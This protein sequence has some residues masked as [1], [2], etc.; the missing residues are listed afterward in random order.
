MP[1]ITPQ[2]PITGIYPY[3]NAEKQLLQLM[4]GGNPSFVNPLIPAI[5]NIL[6]AVDGLKEQLDKI[7]VVEPDVVEDEFVDPVIPEMLDMTEIPLNEETGSV[8][9]PQKDQIIQSLDTLE[10][11]SIPFLKNHSDRLSGANLKMSASITEIFGTSNNPMF[12]L[13]ISIASSYTSTMYRIYGSSESSNQVDH[14]S[15]IFGTI[16]NQPVDN[17]GIN[18]NMDSLLREISVFIQKKSADLDRWYKDNGIPT[19]TE[20]NANGEF[21]EFFDTLFMSFTEIMTSYDTSFRQRATLDNQAYQQ[22]NA[23]LSVV[24]V[25]QLLTSLYTRDLNCQQVINLIS[26]EG[27]DFRILIEEVAKE[28]E[29][30]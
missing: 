1:S 27:S 25:E 20:S 9:F 14:F 19:I 4:L 18:K 16:L 30:G 12:G 21:V 29:G 22:A 15:P 17:Q 10:T 24:A 23:F 2:I 26:P 13:L 5:T 7:T 8:V 3:S 28:K 6:N 11:S